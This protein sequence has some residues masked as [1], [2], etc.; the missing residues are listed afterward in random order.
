MPCL[1]A[2]V[3][4]TNLSLSQDDFM[5]SFKNTKCKGSWMTKIH[6]N[7]ALPQGFHCASYH[8]TNELEKQCLIYSSPRTS[9][10]SLN[11]PKAGKSSV[12]AEIATAVETGETLG[13]HQFKK[14]RLTLGTIWTD[15]VREQESL[16][17]ERKLCKIMCAD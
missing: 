14:L 15:N 13:K 3:E 17:G 11:Q 8:H 16:T 5:E 1:E 7:N 6:F 12:K 9:N 10:S 2:L 4:K